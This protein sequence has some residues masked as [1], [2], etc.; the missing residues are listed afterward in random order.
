MTKITFH[1]GSN[2]LT[3]KVTV[4]ICLQ[5]YY[6]LGW[7][8]GTPISLLSILHHILPLHIFLG[9]G[10]KACGNPPGVQYIFLLA[11]S[12]MVYMYKIYK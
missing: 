5:K 12:T 1:N 4:V 3:A 7:A 11:T 8:P 6:K 9:L 10:F 2:G